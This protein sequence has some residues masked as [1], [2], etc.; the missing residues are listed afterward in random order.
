MLRRKMCSYLQSWKRSHGTECL[1]VNGAREV[2]KLFII[3][4]FGEAEYES[5]V[6]LDFGEHPGY[7]EIFSGS[8]SAKKLYSRITLFVPGARIVPGKTLLSSSTSCRSAQRRASRSSASRRT[9][10]ATS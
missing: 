10:A 1:L 7:R 5:F 9:D 8:L 4:R 2:G 6:K 3:E